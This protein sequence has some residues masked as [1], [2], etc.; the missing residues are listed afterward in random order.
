MVNAHT[1]EIRAQIEYN[2]ALA[3]LQVATSTTL[4]E[5]DVQVDID[6]K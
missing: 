1:A 5:N 2:K 6:D 4:R 3:E